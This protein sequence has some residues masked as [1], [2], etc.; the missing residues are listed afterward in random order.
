[1]KS[2]IDIR[3]LTFLSL[4]FLT[5]WSMRTSGARADEQN[6]GSPRAKVTELFR[7]S[8]P[9]DAT[10]D[11]VLLSV[12]FAPGAGSAPHRHPGFLVG[13][14]LSGELEFQLKDQPLQHLKPGDRFFEPPG[15]VHLVSRNPGHEITEVLVFAVQPKGQPVVLPMH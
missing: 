15:A 10:K 5:V 13:Y 3:A 6:E 14:L 4:A 9:N 8:D 7:A 1:M 11:I 2:V 12:K